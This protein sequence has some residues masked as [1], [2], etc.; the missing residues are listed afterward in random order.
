MKQLITGPKSEPVSVQELKDQLRIE[1][2]DENEYLARLISTAR[3]YAEN[4]SGNKILEQ[5]WSIHYEAFTSP[6]MLFMRPVKSIESVQYYDADN[7]LQTLDS[8]VYE[9]TPYNFHSA[10]HLNNGQS[11]PAVYTRQY[12]VIVNATFGRSLPLKT[13]QH[14]ILL[15]ATNWY[16]N[17]EDATK[18]QLKTIPHGAESLLSQH[19]N[20]GF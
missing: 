6:L 16:R 4:L 15:I 12:P 8:S 18:E 17:R 7:V 20:V 13:E 3:E 1:H 2:D 14:A 10:I 19:L 9:V 11:W 5:Q